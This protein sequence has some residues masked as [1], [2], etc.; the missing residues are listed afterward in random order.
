MLELLWTKHTYPSFWI[1]IPLLLLTT[2]CLIVFTNKLGGRARRANIKD[3]LL[4]KYMLITWVLSTLTFLHISFAFFGGYA[5]E[6]YRFEERSQVELLL[7]GRNNLDYQHLFNVT[8]TAVVIA[9]LCGWFVANGLK[10]EGWLRELKVDLENPDISRGQHGSAHFMTREFFNYLAKNKRDGDLELIGAIYGQPSRAGGKLRR[11][12]RSGGN[13]GLVLSRKSRARGISICGSPG[14]G[15]SAAI[16]LPMI[17]DIMDIGESLVITDPQNSLLP[18]I[19]NIAGVTGHRVFV[20][21][22]TEPSLNHYNLAADID[23]G[24]IAQAVAEVLITPERGDSFWT[25]SGANT[26]AAF[27][28]RFDTLG[29]ILQGISQGTDFLVAKL[30]EVD[31]EARIKAGAFISSMQDDNKKVGLGFLATLEAGTLSAWSNPEVTQSTQRSDFSGATLVDEPTVIVLKSPG[32]YGKVLGPYMGAVLTKLMMDLDEIGRLNP[33]GDS[34]PIPVTFMLEEFPLLGNLSVIPD[35]TNVVRKR[36]IS[37]AIVFQSLS[38]LTA[39]Y[40]SEKAKSLIGSLAT[41]IWFAGC[42][43]ETAQWVSEDLG[44]TTEKRRNQDTR[45]IE[46]VPR[47]LLTP[48]EVKSIPGRKG[49]SIIVHRH[50]AI[51]I[52]GE[53]TW[54]HQSIATY[55]PV[56][57]SRR[58]DWQSK[59]GVAHP[60]SIERPALLK[61]GI[62]MAS[63]LTASGEEEKSLSRL[64]FSD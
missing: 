39:L 16:V 13:E 45:R 26:L 17:A 27:L 12:D 24:L 36:G 21:D 46:E 38:Q 57:F 32:R 50:G 62:D 19:L 4:K 9:A 18:D 31:D 3:P 64:D 59:I 25:R 58:T 22:P 34:I 7:V 15:K 10:P 43:K 40:G 60:A 6:D 61:V 1:S 8:G 11:L 42:D 30:Q 49:V 33:D 48:D 51:Q 14:F 47:R 44:D 63:H 23:S 56:I 53:G 52:T 20:H 2:I 55:E 41:N 5:R 35:N 54:S 28:M 37:I 29:D